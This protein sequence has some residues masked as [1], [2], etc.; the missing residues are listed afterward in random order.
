MNKKHQIVNT[1]FNLVKIYS[2]SGQEEEM[3]KETEKRFKK[4]GLYPLRDSYG[5]VIVQV[6][7]DEKKE[8]LLL[9]AHLDTVEPCKNIKPKISNDNWIISS[10][11]TILGADNKAAVAAIIEVVMKCKEENFSKNCPLDIVFTREEESGTFGAANLDYS[12]IRAKKGHIFDHSG[13]LGSFVL[14][15]PFYNR[16]D[17]EITG[18]SAHASK[19]EEGDNTIDLLAMV[20]GKFKR[21]RLDEDTTLNIRII[22]NGDARNTIPGWVK[23]EGEV[24]SYLEEKV[25]KRTE[26]IRKFFETTLKES[27]SEFLEMKFSKLRENG[28]FKYDEEHNFIKETKKVIE[29]LGLKA[30]GC[31]SMGCSDANLFTENGIMIIDHGYGAIK[32]HTREEAIK[33]DDL[34]MLEK[35]IYNLIT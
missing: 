19:P 5:N 18:R 30:H 26:E 34:I 6:P 35:L 2:P 15:S 11:D 33:I 3:V 23:L 28:G 24:R 21:G 9:S 14:A 10:G 29:N 25:E 7:G 27:G 13:P 16:F 12:M 1:F 31:N 20:L 32:T 4:M 8:P 17:I 22:G